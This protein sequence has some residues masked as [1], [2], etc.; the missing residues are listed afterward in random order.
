MTIFRV[1]NLLE[2]EDQMLRDM[3]RGWDGDVFPWAV[4]TEDWIVTLRE[5]Q[6]DAEHF[7]KE[8][9]RVSRSATIREI[10]E[11]AVLPGNEADWSRANLQEAIDGG[12]IAA[13]ESA[14]WALIG[15]KPGETGE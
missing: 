6:E 7:A 2:Q 15:G 3:A 8:L 4:M 10:A 11:A 9:E 13:V 14:I 5:E 12:E 1:V